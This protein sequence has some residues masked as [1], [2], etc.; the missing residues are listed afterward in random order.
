MQPVRCLLATLG[1]L[2][3]GVPAAAQTA[4]NVEPIPELVVPKRVA[5]QH[6]PSGLPVPRYV[7]L[8]FGRTNGRT[9]PSRNHAV[10]WSYSRRGLPLVVVAETSQWRRVRDI[11]GDESWIKS[12]GLSGERRALALG[13]VEVRR[14]P[15]ADA[16]LKAVTEDGAI[17]RLGACRDGW[18]EVEAGGLSGWAV[19][20]RLWGA[21]PL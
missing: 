20:S 18:C 10:A 12:S 7:S 11:S 15:G 4:R 5:A 17:L 6:T 3:L 13:A 8:K 19:Q 9:G 1:A 2:A 21:Q 14:K 16:R